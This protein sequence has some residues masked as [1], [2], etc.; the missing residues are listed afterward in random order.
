M[1][2]IDPFSQ[3][4]RAQKYC[5]F[6]RLQLFSVS[7][8]TRSHRSPRAGCESSLALRAN[9]LPVVLARSKAAGSKGV[10]VAA[11]LSFALLGRCL[12]WHM[13]SLEVRP[14]CIR[15]C[16]KQ[17]TTGFPCMPDISGPL[18]IVRCISLGARMV[19]GSC[20]GIYYTWY[21]MTSASTLRTSEEKI[22]SRTI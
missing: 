1:V 14:S 6:F 10:Q 17:D 5:C 11:G 15:H 3:L 21:R 18:A 16:M 12:A 8:S 7:N 19:T 9:A 2:L 22:M 4:K 13:P 20:R